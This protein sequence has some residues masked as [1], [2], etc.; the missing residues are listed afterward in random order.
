MDLILLKKNNNSWAIIPPSF[1]FDIRIPADL[2]EELAR[3]YGYDKVPVQ[4]LS[5]DA[6]I[7]QKSQSKVGS[8]D[9]SQALV[10]RGYQEVITYSFISNEYHDLIRP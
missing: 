2:I 10:N 3:L 5:V 6:N 7:S 4:R 9:I 8:Y 1:R